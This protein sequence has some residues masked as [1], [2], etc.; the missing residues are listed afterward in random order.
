[1]TWQE[2]ETIFKSLFEQHLRDRGLLQNDLRVCL[3]SQWKMRTDQKR[4]SAWL[5]WQETCRS[6]QSAKE[7]AR[8]K[9]IM[10]QIREIAES[11]GTQEPSLHFHTRMIPANTPSSGPSTVP[12]P[13]L[14]MRSPVAFW[15][16]QTPDSVDG[17]SHSPERSP[18]PSPKR[19]KIVHPVVLI[20]RMPQDDSNGTPNGPGKTPKKTL[21]LRTPKQTPRASLSKFPYPRPDD[22]RRGLQPLQLTE[23]EHEL[24]KGPLV[25]ITKDRAQPPFTG[26]FYRYA[27]SLNPCFQLKLEDA[28]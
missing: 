11:P 3:R 7:G 12:E 26:L 16:P 24:A 20:P 6:D 4:H 5:E 13:P 21:K 15:N 1:M 2:R 19:R 18:A 10:A 23:K 25:P 27:S 28:A 22:Q 8:R 14:S 9:A 17:D